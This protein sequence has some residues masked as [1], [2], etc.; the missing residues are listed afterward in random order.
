MFV[1]AA[2][3]GS[4]F[5]VNCSEAGDAPWDIDDFVEEGCP[6]VSIATLGDLVE[7]EPFDFDYPVEGLECFVVKLGEPA[8]DGIG[9]DGDI[10]AFSYLCTHMGCSLKSGYN[11]EH[12]ILGPCKCHF[13]TFS[14]RK[15]GMVVLGQATQNLV[16]V[17]LELEGEQIVAMGLEG[18]IY[19][20]L[21]NRC[22]DEQKEQA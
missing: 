19:G 11:H 20:E 17:K 15:R 12:K 1:S 8:Q 7:G 2:G 3:L 18:V 13:T 14:L 4:L 21:R 9:P 22:L 16:Q 10:V 6:P 5:L